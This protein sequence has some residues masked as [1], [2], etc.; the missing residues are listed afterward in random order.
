M[1]NEDFAIVCPYFHKALGNIIFCEGFPGDDSIL[2]T[3][4]LFKQT[5][6]DRKSRNICMKSYC[7]C[8]N[9]TACS[10]AILNEHKYALRFVKGANK[11]ALDKQCKK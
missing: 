6:A 9:Y 8:F 2:G 4:C 10:L 1:P 5:F 11:K 3:E 7:T